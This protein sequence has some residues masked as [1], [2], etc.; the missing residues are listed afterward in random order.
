[1]VVRDACQDRLEA[2]TSGSSGRSSAPSSM[3]LQVIEERVVNV[4]GKLRLQ[5]GAV[6][7]TQAVNVTL[8]IAS[9]QTRCLNCF[10]YK[11]VTGCE[12]DSTSPTCTAE[13][14]SLRQ[15]T[16]DSSL[17]SGLLMPLAPD[18]DPHRFAHVANSDSRKVVLGQQEIELSP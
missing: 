10:Q 15:Q 2:A 6:A 14:L 4:L 3:M 8:P 17:K 1:M 5:A 12:S 13:I 9:R 11:A 7:I 16:V 18:V